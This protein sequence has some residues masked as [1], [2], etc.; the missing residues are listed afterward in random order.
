MGPGDRGKIREM[1]SRPLPTRGQAIALCIFAVVT[2][3]A[4]AGLLS[5]AA[6]VPAPVAVLPLVIAVSI[7]GPMIATWELRPSLAVLRAHREHKRSA[8]NRRIV[9]EMRRFL[10]QLPETKHPL[11][12]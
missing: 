8:A 4:C 1:S 3:L 7:G 2:V 12:G 5:A 10:E 11:D 6:L 9:A